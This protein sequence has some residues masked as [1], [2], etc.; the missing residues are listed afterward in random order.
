MALPTAQVEFKGTFKRE[1]SALRDLINKLWKDHGMSFVKAG[2]DK[3]Y[4]F[5]GNKSMVVFDETLWEGLIELISPGGIITI[6]P[7]EINEFVVSSNN[8]DDLSMK[9]I[10]DE[11]INE[12]D[13]FYQNRYWHT[14]S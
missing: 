8:L 7:A 1:L 13:D 12:I 6:K 2:D 3:V 5:G 11:G 14:P 9:K 4:A 10:M